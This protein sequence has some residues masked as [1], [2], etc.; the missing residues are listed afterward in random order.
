MSRGDRYTEGGVRRILSM[1]KKEPEIDRPTVYYTSRGER[2]VKAEE[3]LRSTRGRDAVKR[4]VDFANRQND[5]K[6]SGRTPE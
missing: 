1:R 5:R 2:Y 4:M 3:L 6:S